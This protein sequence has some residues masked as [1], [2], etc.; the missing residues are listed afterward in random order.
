MQPKL[1]AR[2]GH[3]VAGGAFHQGS[4]RG[5]VLGAGDEV[6]FLTVR[7]VVEA[8]RVLI[9]LLGAAGMASGLP[10]VSV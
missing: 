9:A 1:A 3:E 6:S 8:R 10:A 5:L 4:D 7:G 2:V